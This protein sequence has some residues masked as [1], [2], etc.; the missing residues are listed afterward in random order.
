M[1]CKRAAFTALFKISIDP[2]Y[3]WYLFPHLLYSLKQERSES[4]LY[5]HRLYLLLRSS[6]NKQIAQ[7]IMGTEI[8]RDAEKASAILKVNRRSILGILD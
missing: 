8:H 3:G 1:A 6:S 4:P 7:S 2:D 5:Y